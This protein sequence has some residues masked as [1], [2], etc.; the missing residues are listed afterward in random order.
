MSSWTASV[1]ILFRRRL[2]RALDS[3]G[4]LQAA[5]PLLEEAAALETR[6]QAPP[7]VRLLR[8]KGAGVYA[9]ARYR[10]THGG[11]GMPGESYHP[12]D[13]AA[14]ADAGA[15]GDAGAGRDD[16]VRTD[17][18][19]VRDHDEV[20]ELHALLDDRVLDGAASDGGVGADLDVGTDAHAAD[21]RHLEPGTFLRGKAETVR[22]DDH[23]RL[24]HAACTDLHTGA[25]GDAR[26]QPHVGGEARRFGEVAVTPHG[27]AR[28]DGHALRDVAVRAHLRARVDAGTGR[29]ERGRVH[30]WGERRRRMQERRDARIG[31]VRVGTQ[32]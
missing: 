15:A 3:R 27:A 26:D 24:Q 28:A 32:E 6:D 10:V 16:R 20:V 29:D 19:V 4:A 1:M 18:H 12:T 8:G 7:S 22:A 14:P 21:L 13:H 11:F 17:A 5:Q 25:E 2:P 9:G 30:P 23:A 31:C